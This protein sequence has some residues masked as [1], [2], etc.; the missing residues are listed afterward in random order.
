MRRTL[1][2]LVPL[3]ALAVAGK[4]RAYDRGWFRQ[5]RLRAPVVSIGNL[6][7]GGSGKTPLTIRLAELLS[8]RGVVVDVLSRGYGRRS[9]QVQRVEVAGSWQDY[10]DE[11][12]LVAQQAE[13]PVYVGA[14]R[15]AAAM[16]AESGSPAPQLHLLDDGFQHRQLARDLDIVVLHRSD[17]TEGMLPAGRLRE[18]FSS[19]R[20]ADVLVLREEDRDLESQLRLRGFRQPIWWMIRRLDVPTVTSAIAFCGIARPTEFLNGLT[21]ISI[22]ASRTQRDHYVWTDRDIADL[23][24]LQRRHSAASFVTTEKDLVRLS[25]AQRQ[26][27]EG[28]APL[29]AVRLR[30]QLRDEPATI[31][32]L[33][34]L[35]PAGSRP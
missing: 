14:S 18:P 2:P 16:L 10:G 23:V 1:L 19:L 27:L 20:R 32:H 9:H 35:L 25:P 5:Q 21:G 24:E 8:D 7:V 17:F 12:L 34:E 26:R 28:A 3:Y 6:S 11:P 29:R 33:M 22:P 15:Y 13:V 4:N 30:V 31:D